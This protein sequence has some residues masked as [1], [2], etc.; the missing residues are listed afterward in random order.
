MKDNW[1]ILLIVFFVCC[2]WA[3]MIYAAIHFALKF[4]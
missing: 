4:W 2:A 3:V 1:G